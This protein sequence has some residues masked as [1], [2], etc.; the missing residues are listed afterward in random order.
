MARNKNNLMDTTTATAIN[1]EMK[2]AAAQTWW[3]PLVQGLAVVLFGVFALFNTTATLA[4]ILIGLGV[5]WAVNGFFTIK[6]AMQKESGRA[7]AIIG[8]A[9]GILIGAFAVT[10][11]FFASAIYATVISSMI[12]IGAVV[13]G[14]MQMATGRGS[15]DRVGFGILNVLLGIVILANPVFSFELIVM[16]L[17]GI[18]IVG[19]GALMAVA[20]GIKSLGEG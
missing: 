20:F 4:M 18:A 19:G 11:P 9:A 6:A 17:A 1:L 7:R 16:V 10:Q 3:I 8:G 12:G 5:Y 2:Q 15:W 13:S 14:G